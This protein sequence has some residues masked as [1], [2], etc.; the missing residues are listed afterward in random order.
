MAE[1]LIFGNFS[2]NK[3]SRVEGLESF[4]TLKIQ[5]CV[6][7]LMRYFLRSNQ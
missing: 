3:I 5:C 2:F 7:I 4:D 1:Y 6:K